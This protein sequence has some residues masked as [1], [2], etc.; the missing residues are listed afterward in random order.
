MDVRVRWLLDKVVPKNGSWRATGRRRAPRLEDILLCLPP[1]YVF[2]FFPTRLLWGHRRQF[3]P[4]ALFGLE[5]RLESI[6]ISA[7]SVGLR[8]ALRGE[9]LWWP[10]GLDLHLALEHVAHWD[11]CAACWLGDPSW[12]ATC[13]EDGSLAVWDVES[14]K[15]TSAQACIDN[16]CL[17]VSWE[18]SSSADNLYSGG[19]DGI[20]RKWHWAEGN[21]EPVAS[22]VVEPNSDCGQ[23]Y[24]LEALGSE[25]VAGFGSHCTVVD[26]ETFSEL[27]RWRY[28]TMGSASIGGGRNPNNDAFVFDLSSKE[29]NQILAALSDGTLRGRDSRCPLRDLSVVQVRSSH[30]GG[31]LSFKTSQTASFRLT[32][33]TQRAAPGAVI[34]I[35]HLAV[36][37]A[38]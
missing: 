4:R 24:A 38:R 9:V 21:L 18:S 10:A 3:L 19:A 20:V 6:V 35:V 29:P 33:R 13:A 11:L 25:L 17:R 32:M 1:R 14:G 30:S 22:V 28:A 12:I 23:V 37:A 2:F 5:P 15:A 16:E 34:T 8:W 31:F 7:R 36:E 26:A 27:L